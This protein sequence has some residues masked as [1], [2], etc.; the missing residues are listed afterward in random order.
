[1][2]GSRGSHGRFALLGAVLALGAIGHS[3]LLDRSGLLQSDSDGGGGSDGDADGDGDPA[4]ADSDGDS[5]LVPADAEADVEQDAEADLPE[6]DVEQDADIIEECV[7]DECP[8]RRCVDNACSHYENCRELRDGGHA[9]SDGVYSFDPDGAGPEPEFFAYCD[10]TTDGRGWTL[11]ARTSSG[12]VTGSG[13]GWESATGDVSDES[14]PYSIGATSRG[15]AFSEILFGNHAGGNAWGSHVYRIVGVDADFL[16]SYGS[17]AYPPS[18]RLAPSTVVGD[19]APSGGPAMF[20]HMGRTA[21]ADR[22]F[23][24]DNRDEFPSGLYPDGWHVAHD[25]CDQGAELHR[26]PGMIMVR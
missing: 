22:Y 25:N 15:L 21:N 18:G 23:F 4:D 7:I 5:D 16:T 17:R 12:A 8:G 14:A 24:R 20:W 9:V 11:V 10:M 13:F 2:A 3:C 26:D 6:A 1:M 19:C